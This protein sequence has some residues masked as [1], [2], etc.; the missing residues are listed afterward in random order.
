MN[1]IM[2]FQIFRVKFPTKNDERAKH[3][4]TS[5]IF[6]SR[7]SKDYK[8][9]VIIN[10]QL[11][12]NWNSKKHSCKGTSKSLQELTNVASSPRWNK[13][14][15]QI[16][17]LLRTPDLQNRL[18][19]GR[20]TNV[21]FNS[22]RGEDKVQLFSRRSGEIRMDWTA[23]FRLSEKTNPSLMCFSPKKIKKLQSA[24]WETYELPKID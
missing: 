4:S 17:F 5:S 21:M 22:M 15:K 23:P 11:S 10:L 14:K 19:F 1:L 20:T 8:Y 6:T 18:L 24:A 13:R 9:T 7:I 3:T 16:F 2:I 12:T